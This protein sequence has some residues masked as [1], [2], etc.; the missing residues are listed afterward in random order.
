MK[1]TVMLLLFL[2]IIPVV[3]A[4]I[5]VD[6]P[7]NTI[8]N[9]GDSI[10]I[11]GYVLRPETALGLFSLTLVCDQNLQLLA[12]TISIESNE[13]ILF[14]ES[15]AIPPITG[16]NCIIEAKLEID[17]EII[18]R[19]QSKVFAIT[20]DLDG[21]FNLQ[22]DKIQLGDAIN[23]K[24]TITRI[25]G[26]PINGLATIY[27]KQN[28]TN[29]FVD[30]TLITN[31][32]LDYSYILKS[33]PSGIYD[34]DIQANDGY[35]NQFLFENALNLEIVDDIIVA[36]ELD[37]L[38]IKP[39]EK[40]KISGKAETLLTK[41]IEVGNVKIELNGEIFQLRLKSN[42]AYDY[43]IALKEDI[44]SGQHNI[45]VLVED[46]LG[47]NGANEATFTVIPIP[48]QLVNTLDK[49]EYLPEDLLL[50]SSQLYDQA[51][52]P[53]DDTVSIEI[54][55]S[56]GKEVLKKVVQTGEEVEYSLPQFAL[57]GTWNIKTFSSGLKKDSNFLVKEV[58]EVQVTVENDIITIT[59]IGNVD[60]KR[61]VEIILIDTQDS[62][63][64]KK[65]TLKPGKSEIVYLADEVPSG[66]Y[67]LEINYDDKTE[68]F[69]NVL[70]ADGKAPKTPLFFGLLILVII[71][72]LIY[73][74]WRMKNNKGRNRKAFE[75]D[76]ADGKRRAREL[77]QLKE[78]KHPRKRIAFGW[79]MATEKEDK[80]KKEKEEAK[81]DNKKGG[82]F[83]M[84]D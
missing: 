23:I 4:E 75:K 84:F 7:P 77:K 34:A 19:K 29:Y 44:T 66:N 58:I 40:L 83:S 80:I 25:N 70:V 33:N 1:R 18:E 39:G 64:L 71:S 10:S 43:E 2:L 73:I 42:N 61:P 26:K 63:I 24:G 79:R 50:I 20:R 53:I 68:I 6:G 38:E 27:L 49:E 55:D 78:E 74:A 82:L 22:K 16:D 5:I 59:N 47:N 45:K 52:D 12:R 31:S 14:L 35:G 69:R 62:T 81:K 37:N 30:T 36:L 67:N 56:E 11:S 46:S 15:L 28:G 9:L 13:K 21:I 72:L 3:S 32:K 65:P 51:N 41:D 54:K 17:G 48:T 57:P 76:L 8:Y 60:Y